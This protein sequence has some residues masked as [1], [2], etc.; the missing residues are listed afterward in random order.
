MNES[1]QIAIQQQI[2]LYIELHQY[3]ATKNTS[4]T[5]NMIGE[6]RYCKGESGRARATDCNSTTGNPKEG[7][8]AEQ[9]GETQED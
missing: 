6:L 3:D 8:G 4:E 7:E 2:Y 1:Q 9:Q 5:A